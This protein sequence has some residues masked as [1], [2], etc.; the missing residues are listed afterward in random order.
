MHPETMGGADG[1]MLTALVVSHL[2]CCCC[3]EDSVT[4]SPFLLFLVG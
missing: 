1:W 3:C 4:T 2:F